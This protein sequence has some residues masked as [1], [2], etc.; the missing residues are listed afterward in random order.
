[1]KVIITIPA[2]NEEKTLVRTISD[3]RIVMDKTSYN[4]KIH[5]QDDGS[6]D[7]TFDLA[8]KYADFANSNEV[9]QG[10]FILN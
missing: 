9:N 10:L 4:Y 3:I 8:K 6:D 1:M 7:K 5:V 2:Y